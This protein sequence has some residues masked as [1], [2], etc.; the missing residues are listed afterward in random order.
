MAVAGCRL[1]TSK[2]SYWHGYPVKVTAREHEGKELTGRE[3]YRLARSYWPDLGHYAAWPF[4]A[5]F[6]F[7]RSIPYLSD[8]DR[9]P[10][11]VVEV[12]ARPAH[13]LDRRVFPRL[14]CKKKSILIGAW[15]AANGKPFRFVAVSHRPDKSI[16]H[17]FPQIDFGRGWVNVDATFPKFEIGQPQPATFATELTP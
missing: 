15:A 7:V 12:V 10:A 11:R 14:D 9:F 6:R 17:V 8:E 16:H 13:I 2:V 1:E 3:M 5:W 4:A